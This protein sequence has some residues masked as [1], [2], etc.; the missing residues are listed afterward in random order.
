MPVRTK[1]G[2]PVDDENTSYQQAVGIM[3]QNIVG[4]A[5]IAPILKRVTEVYCRRRGESTDPAQIVKFIQSFQV[6]WKQAARCQNASTA[7][8]C[9]TRFRNLNE[10]FAR[11]KDPKLLDIRLK[12][13]DSKILVSPAD[14]RAVVFRSEFDAKKFWIK[15]TDYNVKAL[16]GNNG[17]KMAPGLHEYYRDCSVIISRLAPVDY[18]RFHSPVDGRYA[19]HYKIPGGYY[20]VQP[21]IVN[22]STNVFTENSRVVYFINS[23]HFGTVALVIIGATC[24]GSIVVPKKNKNQRISRGQE[25]GYF[26]F[27]GSTIVT[28]VSV[29]L[30]VDM[31]LVKHGVRGIETYLRTG[32]YIATSKIKR[33]H[34]RGKR[35]SRGN[36]K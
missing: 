23:R 9:A 17:R 12:G 28:L 34:T 10:F 27:G 26:K 18:H 15:G 1:D 5:I 29:P 33:L 4:S 13:K 24:V 6:D 19:T 32:D 30:K 31:P 3:L 25:L 16:L 11:K 7:I 2:R 8:E 21:N 14:S 35:G 22:S 20:S 36:H